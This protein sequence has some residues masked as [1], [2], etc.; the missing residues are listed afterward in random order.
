MDLFKKKKNLSYSTAK[1]DSMCFYVT[2]RESRHQLLLSSC[3]SSLEPAAHRLKDFIIFLGT[4]PDTIILA[5]ISPQSFQN[6][7]GS[8]S[9]TFPTPFTQ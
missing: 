3:R 7:P 6:A 8:P 4:A 9:P 5:F 2:S 1:T